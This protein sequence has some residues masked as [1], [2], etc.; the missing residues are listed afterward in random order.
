MSCVCVSCVCVWT[1]KSTYVQLNRP[2][3]AVSYTLARWTLKFVVNYF[4]KVTLKLVNQHVVR[5]LCTC[6]EMVASVCPAVNTTMS[7]VV[8]NRLLSAGRMLHVTL[9]VPCK[10]PERSIL[11]GRVC[12][13]VGVGVCVCVGVR[14]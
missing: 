1:K 12:V 3:G 7:E 4:R 13:G 10:P 6:T 11:M 14:R 9:T 8:T 5:C 2:M